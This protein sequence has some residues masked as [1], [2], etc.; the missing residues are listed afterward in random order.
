MAFLFAP[1][2][3][4]PKQQR[5]KT[6]SERIHPHPVA[7]RHPSPYFVEARGERQGI[8]ASGAVI[9]YEAANKTSIRVCA[10]ADAKPDIPAP[11]GFL[12]AFMVDVVLGDVLGGEKVFGRG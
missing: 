11:F 5:N 1:C 10:E 6:I 9:W 3:K 2:C 4:A 7:S 12:P 8:Q